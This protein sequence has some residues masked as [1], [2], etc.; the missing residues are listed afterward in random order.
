MALTQR[1]KYRLLRLAT[2][3]SRFLLAGTFMFSGAIKAN[4]PYGTVYKL[5]DYLAS[6]GCG[7]IPEAFIF[8]A[9][10][11]LAA[12]E[13]ILGAFLL[14]G[15]GRKQTARYTFAFMVAMTLLTVYIYMYDPVSD[16]GC[17]GDLVILTNGQTLAKNIV[18]LSAAIINMRLERLN[19]KWVGLGTR[20][21]LS[22]IIVVA[23][24]AFG[25]YC[26][27]Y[28]PVFDYRPYRVGTDLR[29]AFTS[30]QP[31]YDV[32]FVYTRGGETIRLT[33]EDDDPDSTWTYVE[34][35][36]TLI[37]EGSQAMAEFYV[38]DPAT[39]EDVTE[40]II[41]D[42][43]YTFLLIVPDLRNANEDCIDLVNELYEYCKTNSYTF[44]CLTGTT[45]ETS[46]TY[47][48][49]H[50]GA[51][52]AYLHCDERVLKTVIRS[53]PGLLLIHDGVIIN[54]WSSRQIPDEYDLSDRLENLPDIAPDKGHNT[55]E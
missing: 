27:A 8:G 9:A 35:E 21:L 23:I 14:F 12:G 47:W 33:E 16:C 34:T 2:N 41:Y 30:G 51:E 43:G 44:Y 45:D 39:D 52:Y 15:I 13:F 6:F 40:D 38:T 46:T 31:V 42:D 36:R 22:L 26:A 20:S 10:I 24:T 19:W 37:S 54:K 3:A 49:D 28:L 48:T 50:T 7:N 18:L 5:Y 32:R 29:E 55:E 53:T 17:F 4:D 25:I 11:A 1:I